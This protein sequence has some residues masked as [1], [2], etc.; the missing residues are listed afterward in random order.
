MP[1]DHTVEETRGNEKRSFSKISEIRESSGE[2]MGISTLEGKSKK[3][4]S[5]LQKLDVQHR[6][7]RSKNSEITS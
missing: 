2:P 6:L 3:S 7:R 5:N 4:P 1:V